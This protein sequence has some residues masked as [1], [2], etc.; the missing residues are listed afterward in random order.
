MRSHLVPRRE[1]AALAA[2]GSA[3]KE[4]AQTTSLTAGQLVERIRQNLGVAWRGSPTGTFKSGDENSPVTG[5][6]TTAMSTFEVIQK[7]GR[8][9]QEH[10]HHARAGLLDDVRNF[11]NDPV[12]QK[13]LQ[14]IRD[15]KMVIWRF[16]DH[17]HWKQPGMTA[18]GLSDALP[19]N[20]KEGQVYVLK[21]VTLRELAKDVKRLKLN[22]IGVIGGPGQRVSRGALLQ[23]A[24]PFHDSQ[25][26]PSVDVVAAGEQRE[27]EG[28]E[29]ASDTNPAGMPKG[30]ILIGRWASEQQGMRLC[31]DWLKTFIKE[32]P[33][34]WIPAGDPFWRP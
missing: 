22:A 34:E 2:L 31:A 24:P 10:G 8:R 7:R 6:A 4:F 29:Y 27:W 26:L 23:G 33:V 25:T 30:M 16:H 14:F 18:A 20:Q 15:N 3:L 9:R 32:M 21:P 13:K 11:G 5:V 12:D 28:V 1:F 17:M 19:W